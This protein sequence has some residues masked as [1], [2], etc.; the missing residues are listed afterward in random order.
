MEKYWFGLNGT[1][2]FYNFEYINYVC[3]ILI[4]LML[5]AWK[6][7]RL[8]EQGKQVPLIFGSCWNFNYEA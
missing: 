2:L 3:I 5:E 6:E 4:E 1:L 7:A 8:E